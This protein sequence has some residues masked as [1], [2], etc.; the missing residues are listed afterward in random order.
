MNK[1]AKRVNRPSVNSEPPTVSMMPANQRS[2]NIA[3]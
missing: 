3:G 1:A 2:V